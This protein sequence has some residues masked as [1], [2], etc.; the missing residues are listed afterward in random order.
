M[1]IKVFITYQLIKL[2]LLQMYKNSPLFSSIGL[3]MTI[4][5]MRHW[6]GQISLWEV[7]LPRNHWKKDFSITLY[8]QPVWHH[9]RVWIAN[10]NAQITFFS[11]GVLLYT[12]KQYEY[13]INTYHRLKLCHMQNLYHQHLQAKGSGTVWSYQTPRYS[14]TAV[15]NW[16]NFNPIFLDYLTNYTPFVFI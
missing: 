2:A 16:S 7:R 4:I 8:L 6:G 15:I 11:K 13:W 12:S 3:K 1:H 5:Q 10:F 14:W 9:N